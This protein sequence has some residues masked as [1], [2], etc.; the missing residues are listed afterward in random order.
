MRQD[1]GLTNLH[2]LVGGASTGLSALQFG[3]DSFFGG[4]SA[5][6]G[7]LLSPNKPNNNSVQSAYSK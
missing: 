7:F 5:A 2:P 3:L 6:G 4:S 1:W